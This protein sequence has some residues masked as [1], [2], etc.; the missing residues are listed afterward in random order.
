MC[1]CEI[2]VFVLESDGL[3][4]IEN[5]FEDGIIFTSEETSLFLSVHIQTVLPFLLL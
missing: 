1:V 5:S 4:N 3:I 2:M